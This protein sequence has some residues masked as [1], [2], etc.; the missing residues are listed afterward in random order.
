MTKNFRIRKMMLLWLLV[1]LL[2]YIIYNI[3]SGNRGIASIKALRTKH[4]L[5]EN[6]LTALKEQKSSQQK[7]IKQMQNKSLDADLL[8]EQSRRNLGVAKDGESVYI[9]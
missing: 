2:V 1:L 8:D 6:E 5:L 7:Q 9:D 3:F 4:D